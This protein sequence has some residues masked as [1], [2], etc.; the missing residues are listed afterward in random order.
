MPARIPQ[1]P[2]RPLLG[3]L[4]YMR[5]PLTFFARVGLMF[6]EGLAYLPFGRRKVLLVTARCGDANAVCFSPSSAGN[7][8]PVGPL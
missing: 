7:A 6:P 1:V 4:P 8:S 3:A 5:D 2:G